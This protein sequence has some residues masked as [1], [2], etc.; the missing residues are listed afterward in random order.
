M[1][2]YW[3]NLLATVVVVALLSYGCKADRFLNQDHTLDTNTRTT[4]QSEILATKA[5]ICRED[6][7]L[8]DTDTNTCMDAK[9]FCKL[10]ETEGYVYQNELCLSPEQQCLL[11]KGSEWV[12]G[13]CKSA[14]VVCEEK[15]DGSTFV[16]G[17]CLN[18]EEFCK[19]K[20]EH[21]V[22]STRNNECGLRGFLNYC[23]DPSVSESAFTTVLELKKIA[24]TGLGLQRSPT[25]SESFEFLK[26]LEQL[27]L[28]H[29]NK[30]QDSIRIRDLYPLIEFNGIK[31]LEL[32]NQGINDL[33]PL[34][35]LTQLE[36]LDLQN[37]ELDE[38][39]YVSGL[40]KLRYLFLGYNR[41]ILSL[42]GLENL[43]NLEVLELFG[44]TISNLS[45][46]E[47]LKNLRRLSLRDNPINS[48]YYLRLMEKLD[49]EDGLD[50]LYTNI[51]RL[52][53]AQRNEQNC[54]SKGNISEALKKFC[55]TE[56]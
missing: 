2:K 49:I 33:M 3:P 31:Q 26:G 12:D 44:A 42:G 23:Q 19:S 41:S 29:D 50:L 32:T 36:Y 47:Q 43:K 4:E 51:S 52:P 46:L 48:V 8:W 15:S 38:L 45:P 6:D 17:T 28:V 55:Q 54:P 11:A 56:P 10:K 20:G 22:W 40:V 21:Y 9:S 30:R 5:A 34:S 53:L 25:C 27:R 35:Y 1:S 13:V 14:S 16:N 7:K 37:N 18:P 39:V 24:K